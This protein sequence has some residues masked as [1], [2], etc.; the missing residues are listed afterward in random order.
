[1]HPYLLQANQTD[2]DFLL[3]RAR[4]IGFELLVDDKTLRFRKRRNDRGQTTQLSF[5]KGL[6]RF[7]G[8]L[9]TADQVSA[10]TVRGWNPSAKD[11]FVGRAEAGDV[12]GR[13]GG[14]TS[15]PAA[16]DTTWGTRTL[17]IVER[18][19]ATQNEADLLARGLLNVLALEYLVADVLASGNPDLGSGS[20]VELGGLGSRFSGLY[21]V[22]PCAP[23]PR[24]G[25]LTHLRVRRNAT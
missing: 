16:A 6:Q 5:T 17:G 25:Y 21:Y 22:V 12:N 4:T 20:V 2:V 15:A 19:V 13:M 23:R 8:Y 24:R 18:P 7:E 11:A 1:M 3:A 14:N 10:V 9:S